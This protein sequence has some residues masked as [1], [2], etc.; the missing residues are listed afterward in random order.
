[1]SIASS[2]P[3]STS[4]PISVFAPAVPDPS[5]TP[6]LSVHQAP[7]LSPTRKVADMRIPPVALGP[8]CSSRTK[9]EA[10]PKGASYEEAA[11]NPQHL[12][13]EAAEAQHEERKVERDQKR[14]ELTQCMQTC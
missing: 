6:T 12:T 11:S 4:L 2:A 8:R 3:Q 1:M 13:R 7:K 9:T 14:A 10:V 5:K